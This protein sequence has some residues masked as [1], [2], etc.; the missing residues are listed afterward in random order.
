MSHEKRMKNKNDFF[1]FQ[2]CTKM[3]G[4][5]KMRLNASFNNQIHLT[6]CCLT[7]LYKTH[8]LLPTG[9]ILVCLIGVLMSSLEIGK[10]KFHY[11]PPV[12]KF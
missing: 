7:F 3:N 12:L 1:F 11:F 9:F 4:K 2:R 10:Y 6:F 8:L 5:Q